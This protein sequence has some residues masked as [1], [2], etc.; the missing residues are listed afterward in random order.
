MGYFNGLYLGPIIKGKKRVEQIQYNNLVCPNNDCNLNKSPERFQTINYKFCPGCGSKMEDKILYKEYYS[1]LY[2][3]LKE[4]NFKNCENLTELG[5]EDIYSLS[6]NEFVAICNI[7]RTYTTHSNT[8]VLMNLP[9]D[10]VKRDAIQNFKRDHHSELEVIN[11]Y[12]DCVEIKY[13]II[14]LS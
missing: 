8:D 12:M 6:P 11:K 14:T 1:N 3:I 9:S 7:A 5:P 13:G 10:K 2:E 4:N